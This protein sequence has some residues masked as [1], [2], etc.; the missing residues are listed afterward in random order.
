[1]KKFVNYQAVVAEDINFSLG[2]D[3][4]SKPTIQMFMGAAAADVALISPACVTNWPRVNGD[5]NFGTHKPRILSLSPTL[6][7]TPKVD[8]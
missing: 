4:N 5:G 6:R 8:R 2:T 1:M 3:R 7:T